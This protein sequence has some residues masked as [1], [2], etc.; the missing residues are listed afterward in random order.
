MV[1]HEEAYY[2][3]QTQARGVLD[4]AALERRFR[5]L[6]RWYACRLGPFLPASRQAVWLDLPCGYGNFLYFLRR[7]GYTR[8]SGYDAD[9]KQVHLARLLDLPAE[10]RDAF[11]VLDDNSRSFDAIASVDFLE[12]L[13]RDAAVRFLAACR[14]RLR[15]AG[16]LILRMPCADGPFGSHDAW[17]DLTHQWAATSNLLRSLLQMSGFERIQILDERP[18]PYNLRNRIRLLAFHAARLL[19]SLWVAALGV[20]PPAVW[21]LS[22]WAVAYV[23]KDPVE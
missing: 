13:S 11:A 5:S 20:T 14:A 15:P 10:E 3:H 22:M 1:S 12:H 16:V 6:A 4:A 23:P 9:P 2:A 19:T 21:S 17:N 7:M 8:I 18:Q